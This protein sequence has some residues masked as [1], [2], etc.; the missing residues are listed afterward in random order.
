MINLTPV[1]KQLLKINVIAF[2]I[3]YLLFE[4]GLPF[5]SQ[6]LLYPIQSEE[7]HIYQLVS[8]MF[9]HSSLMH[10]IFNM[11]GLITFGLF[12][13]ANSEGTTFLIT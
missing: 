11:L 2:I 6:F 1:V 12:K 10:I 4:M 3:S 9:L 8:Y 7:F 5:V 13:Q